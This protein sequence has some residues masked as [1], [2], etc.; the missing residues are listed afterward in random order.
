MA[1]EYLRFTGLEMQMTF[2]IKKGSW[3][4][5]MKTNSKHSRPS[6]CIFQQPHFIHTLCH[7]EK[8]PEMKMLRISKEEKDPKTKTPR[9]P[10]AAIIT[11]ST[12]QKRPPRSGEW[13]KGRIGNSP[14]LRW[15]C[16]LATV[17]LENSLDV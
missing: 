4:H 11:K 14:M 12:L 15:D 7:R 1:A 17:T 5:L 2:P 3:R 9:H 8:S 6:T 16:K 10:L 13:S